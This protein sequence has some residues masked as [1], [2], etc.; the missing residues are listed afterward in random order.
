MKILVRLPNWLGD[1]VMSVGFLHQLQKSF[2]EAAISVIAKKG[3]HELLPF[4]P[5]T[6]HQF[7][8]DKAANSGLRGLWRFGHSI[9]SIESFDLFF[10]LPPS[11]S[12]AFMG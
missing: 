6:K 1:M 12:A 11:F 7:V 5:P 3:I 4:F 2:P 8:F 9:K 10:C